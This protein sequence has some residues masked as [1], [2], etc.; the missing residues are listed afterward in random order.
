MSRKNSTQEREIEYRRQCVKDTWI[1]LGVFGVTQ[2]QITEALARDYSIK[3][4]RSTVSRDLTAINKA[5]RGRTPD[6]LKG[7]LM[8]EYEY[9][10]NEARQGWVKSKEDVVTETTEMIEAP[11]AGG[12]RFKAF[13]RRVGQAGDSSFLAEIRQTA[14]S[15]R[16]MFGVDAAAKVEHGGIGGGPI[17][18]VEMRV[19]EPVDSQ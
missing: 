17:Q 19:H 4:D 2:D 16:E 11:D 13:T 1:K 3:V 12:Q 7:Y 6:D 15:I 18:I 5:M 9:L 14:K 10:I 8:A